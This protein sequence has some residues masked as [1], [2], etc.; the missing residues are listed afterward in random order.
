M[1]GA[2][3]VANLGLF[4]VSLRC[5]GALRFPPLGPAILEPDLGHGAP[6]SKLK[7]QQRDIR[8]PPVANI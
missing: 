4:D 3:A 8:F 2:A 7:L 6:P 5:L 1:R